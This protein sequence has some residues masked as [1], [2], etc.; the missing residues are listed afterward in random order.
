MCLAIRTRIPSKSAQQWINSFNEIIVVCSSPASVQKSSL[1]PD[2][3]TFNSEARI[4]NSEQHL[5]ANRSYFVF[6]YT[7]VTVNDFETW[8]PDASLAEVV[9]R[10]VRRRNFLNVE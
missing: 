9:R 5:V 4:P 2:L 7:K 8:S 10:V 6:A 3:H 1:V